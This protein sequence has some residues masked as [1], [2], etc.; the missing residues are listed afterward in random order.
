MENMDFLIKSQELAYAPYHQARGDGFSGQLLLASEIKDPERKY[1]I[2]AGEAHVAACE[3]MFYR[4]ALKLGLGVAR[5]RMVEPARHGEF[6]YPACAVDYIPNAVKLPYDEYK[7]IEECRALT[8][9]SYMLGDWDHMDFLRDENGAVYKID[10][11]DCF[12]IEMTAETW[13]DPQKI[14]PAYL[15]YQ[16]SRPRPNA[17]YSIKEY[18]GGMPAKIAKMGIAEFGDEFYLLKNCCGKP[19]EDHFRYY[20]SEL[21][22]QCKQL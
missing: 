14:N 10:H 3:F 13:L 21:I 17:G 7:G 22:S 4:L 9:L 19:F 20:I 12:G 8:D 15:I 6:K 1:I 2:K 18:A 5:V 16:M 11:S